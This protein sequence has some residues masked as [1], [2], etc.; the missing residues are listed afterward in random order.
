M[1]W[2]GPPTPRWPHAMG[3][4]LLAP[5]EDQEEADLRRWTASGPRIAR[6]LDR[7]TA[8][9]A[10]LVQGRLQIGGVVLAFE[11]ARRLVPAD[12]T[13]FPEQRAPQC[14]EVIHHRPD[15][16]RRRARRSQHPRLQPQF[17]SPTGRELAGG[18]LEAGMKY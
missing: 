8:H 13:L 18:V 16:T 11:Q 1:A 5:C 9:L 6:T 2:T 17:H 12:D 15:P 7:P 10:D 4:R 3:S 14:F